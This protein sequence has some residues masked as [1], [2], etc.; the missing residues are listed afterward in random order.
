MYSNEVYANQDEHFPCSLL[1]MLMDSK[2]VF[3]MNLLGNLWAD[4][5]A[6]KYESMDH[7][8]HPNKSLMGYLHRWS[9]LENTEH[10]VVAGDIAASK[11]NVK[12]HYFYSERKN[13]SAVVITFK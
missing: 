12:S 7:E 3:K 2:I 1:R 9:W 13:R 4:K 10:S 8:A 11:H 5:N 6:G